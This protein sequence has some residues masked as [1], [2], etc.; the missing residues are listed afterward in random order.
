MAINKVAKELTKAMKSA[1]KKETTPYDTSATVKRIENGTA[2]VQIPGGVD[3]T[4]VQMTMAAKVGDTVQVR[5]SGGRAW[6]QGNA[7]APPTDD[8]QAIKATETATAA[9]MAA[10]AAIQYAESASEAA[11]TAWSYADSAMVSATSAQTSAQNASEYASRSLASL[12]TVQSVSETLTWITQHGTMTLTTDTQL[13]PTH[14]YFVVDATGDYV[15]NNTHYS[16][17]TEPN[18][19]G[20]STYYELS[21][22]ESLNNYVGTH[23]ALTGE[24]LWLLPASSGTNKVLIATGAGTTYTTP[25]TYIINSTGGVEASFRSNGATIGQVMNGYSRTEIGT[26]GMQIIQRASGSDTQIAQLGYDLGT[27]ESGTAIAPYYT[28][29]TRAS[30]STLGNYSV[31]EGRLATASGYISHAEGDRTTATGYA[32]HTEGEQTSALDNYSHAEGRLTYASG[33]GAHAEGYTDTKSLIDGLNAGTIR[34]TAMGAHAEGSAKDGSLG[35]SIIAKGVGSHAE[36][37]GSYDILAQGKGSHA[38]GCGTTATGYYS[39]A[40]GF[41]TETAGQA[42]HAQNEGTQANRYAQTAVGTY[43]I[44]D[45]KPSTAVHPNGDT[46]YGTYAL[47]V[48]NGTASSNTSNAAAVDWNG[49]V[50]VQGDVYVGCN[51]DSTGGSK[52]APGIDWITEAGLNSSWYYRKWKSGKIE[53]WRTQNMGSQTPSQWATG[54]YYKD[55]DVTIPS[56]IFASAPHNVLATNKGDDYQFMVFTA[57][58]TSATSIRVRVVKPNSGA[59]TPNLSIYVSNMT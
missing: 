1:D 31:A 55:L 5:V 10:D 41:L 16:L 42:A 48:G 26:N 8:T 6:L 39:H 23:L 24:G 12:S 37:L 36:G 54:W 46:N 3:E 2:W 27:A 4:P 15:V 45:P 14:V 19:D 18:A 43:N 32:S 30:N 40:E 20:L 17:V 33:L 22:D 29:G 9:S 57:V 13:D 58:P 21:I 50:R 52:L 38:E 51:N 47:I 7:T 25:G 49:N 11:A 53:A 35:G 44:N 59:A 56:G 28:F 34:A